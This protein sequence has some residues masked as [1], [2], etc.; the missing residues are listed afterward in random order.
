MISCTIPAQIRKLTD[1]YKNLTDPA[2]WNQLASMF[3]YSLMGSDS[4]SDFVRKNPGIPQKR[5]TVL[6][7]DGINFLKLHWAQVT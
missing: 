7:S 3:A 5:W 2:E 1:R 6:M 4:L